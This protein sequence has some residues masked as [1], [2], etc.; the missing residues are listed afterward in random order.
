[1]PTLV[2][3]GALWGDEA[4][5]KLVDVLASDADYVVRYSGGNNAGH[6]VQAAGH[7]FKF[8]LIPSGVLHKNVTAVLGAGMVVC[9][10]AFL[11]ELETTKQKSPELGRILISSA[12]HVVFPYH[13]TLDALEEENRGEGKI[14]TTSRGIGP[15]YQ[16]KVARVGIRMCEFVDPERFRARLCEVVEYK[17]RVLDMHGKP[18]ISIE[19]II[20]E[21]S[22][23]ADK[24]RPFVCDADFEVNRA[25]HAGKRVIFEGAQGAMLDLDLGTYPFVTS[26]HP[27]AGG[28][29]LVG[30]PPKKVDNVLGVCVAYTT[31]VGSGPFPTELSGEFADRLRIAGNE[32]G[33]STG[34]PRRVGWLD[35]VAL[36]HSCL[37][38]GF[39]SLAVTRVDVLS[40]FGSI[41]ACV[42][43]KIGDEVTT[44]FPADTALLSRAEPQFETLEGWDGDLSACKSTNELPSGARGLIEFIERYTGVPVSLVSVGPNR[45]ETIV[46]DRGLL[47]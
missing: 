11:D 26:S 14:G 6:T 16:D 45:E 4:K 22:A 9:P 44:E 33:T 17:N 42:G 38:N 19:P 31:R 47:I 27:T 40:G 10:K 39:T 46:R 41:K 34:R 25:I 8:H 2:I 30:L 21:Y 23:Y 32:F 12:A 36:R 29:C 28:A 3:I 5:G 18:G 43:Y 13:R 20:E 37:M 7:T 35:L 1:M 15:A 24:L